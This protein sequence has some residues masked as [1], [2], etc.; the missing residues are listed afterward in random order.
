M[1]G[2]T[3][4]EVSRR[5]SHQR[6][7]FLV[8][9]GRFWSCVWVAEVHHNFP[10]YV[11]VPTHRSHAYRPAL[12]F[13]ATHSTRNE[14]IDEEMHMDVAKAVLFSLHNLPGGPRRQKRY[15]VAEP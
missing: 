7:T 13:E 5:I 4:L 12:F 8:V 10:G 9:E 6:S 11:C 2:A 3:S 1:P 15:A 14:N